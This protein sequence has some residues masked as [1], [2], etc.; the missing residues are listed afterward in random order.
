MGWFKRKEKVLKYKKRKKTKIALVLSGGAGRG[1]GHIGAIKAFEKLGI[2]FDIVVGT[3][4]GSAVGAMYAYG[5]SGNEMEQVVARLKISDIKGN[6]PFFLPSSTKALEETISRVMGG[7][8]VF[9]ELKIPFVAVATNLRTGNEVRIGSGSVSK[10]V[11]SSCAVPAYFKPITWD[12][13]VL[14]D[15]GLVNSVP[16]DVAKEMGADYVIA[17]DVNGTRGEGTD[18]IKLG[19]IISSTIGIMLKK[20]AKSFLEL[21]DFC[22]FPKLKEFKSTKLDNYQAMIDEGERATMEHA[23]EIIEILNKKPKKKGFICRG[24]EI[25]YI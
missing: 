23:Q 9:S 3:S 13:K 22:I 8:K 1:I 4:A 15:G 19:N 10:A 6:R 24:T 2:M 17:V 14:V 18:K 16:I 12:D 5:F 20:N 11:A 7:E 21:A 25:E